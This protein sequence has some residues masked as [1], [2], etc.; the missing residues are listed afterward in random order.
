MPEVLKMLKKQVRDLEEDQIK[1]E[2]M[3]SFI[4][5]K[6]VKDEIDEATLDQI[7]TL[8]LSILDYFKNIEE[9]SLLLTKKSRFEDFGIIEGLSNS[10]KD[11]KTRIYELFGPV[12]L[13]AFESRV[14]N[15]LTG[16]MPHKLDKKANEDHT[17]IFDLL[18]GNEI[19]FISLLMEPKE[20]LRDKIKGMFDEKSP[21]AVNYELKL[22]NS[23]K[24]YKTGYDLE[25]TKA[26]DDNFEL[27]KQIQKYQEKLFEI[28][29]DNRG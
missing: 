4:N 19:E 23:M 15:N 7:D 13:N 6:G 3:V 21:A 5:S 1:I 10:I 16:K 28:A 29:I 26:K 22:A 14:F 17:P 8:R 12:V 9:R 24:E 11:S 25:I 27:K 20:D 18:I 2:A